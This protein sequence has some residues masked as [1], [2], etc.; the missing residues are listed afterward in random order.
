[1]KVLV[2]ANPIAG[3]GKARE[4]AEALESE[5]VARGHSVEIFLTEKAGDGAERAGRIGPDVDCIVSVGGD[6]TL[7][8][9]INGLPDG[10]QVPITQL[11]SGTANILAHELGFPTEPRSTA[12]LI[13]TGEVHH[14]DMGLVGDRRFLMVVSVGFDAM[15][16]QYILKNRGGKLGYR[17]YVRPI[18]EVL[19]DYVPAKLAVTVDDELPVACEGVI[20]SSTRNYGGLFKI[21]G[22]A[23][24]DSGKLHVCI[25][26]KASLKDI[27]QLGIAGLMRGVAKHRGVDYRTG[28]RVAI[29]AEEP[30]PV[31]ID[32]DYAG[33]TPID[34]ELRPGAIP[35]LV[36]AAARE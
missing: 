22:D 9:V 20:A 36:P 14:I 32:G 29:R 15:V 2:I 7:N 13:D 24:P 35:I 5:L 4:Q 6:G 12:D 34:I 1:V 33:T 28:S 27:I 16:T 31:E 3:G 21:A 18:L 8:D 17:G 26:E 30:A 23:R 10:N 19:K 25:I 11:P